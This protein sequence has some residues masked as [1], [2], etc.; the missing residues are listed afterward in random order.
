MAK[1]LNLREKL[2]QNSGIVAI[3][4]MVVL[5]LCLAIIFW[6]DGKPRMATAWFLDLNNM[7]LVELPADVTAPV[8]VETGPQPAVRAHVYAEGNCN[9]SSDRKIVYLEQLT[10]AAQK[11]KRQLDTAEMT[12]ELHLRLSEALNSGI[13]VRRVQDP[14]WVAAN[15]E[16]GAEILDAANQPGLQP[17]EPDQ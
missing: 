3:A 1:Q 12:P 16:Q 17:C 11:A 7:Q 9:D 10:D 15:S 2:S 13:L 14:D 8:E 4:C 6:P 5:L